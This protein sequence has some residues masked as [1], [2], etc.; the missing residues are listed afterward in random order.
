ML[1]LWYWYSVYTHALEDHMAKIVGIRPSCLS[2]KLCHSTFIASNSAQ[3]LNL[4]FKYICWV[5][6]VLASTALLP[7]NYYP[8]LTAPPSRSCHSLF[9]LP[10]P[11]LSEQKGSPQ[12]LARKFR[13]SMWQWPVG[14]RTGNY[15]SEFF[16]PVVLWLVFKYV[17]LM[18]IFD[19]AKFVV[20]SF[21]HTCVHHSASSDSP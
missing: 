3:L 15:L 12:G 7:A 19:L 20:F 17:V 16:R 21:N 13:V 8:T 10:S 1:R 5:R 2:L 14:Q 18:F 4:P 9:S 11:A 6:Y